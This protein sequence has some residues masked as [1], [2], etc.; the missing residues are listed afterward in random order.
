[1]KRIAAIQMTSSNSINENLEKIA[2]LVKKSV[3]QGAQ[4]VV[5]PENAVFIGQEETDKIQISEQVGKGP[6]QAFMSKIAK[7]YYIWLIGGTIPIKTKS[8]QHVFASCFVWD[9][10]GNAIARYDK[11][12]LFDVTVNST[13][14]YFESKTISPGHTV[15]SVNSPF[16]KIGLTICYDL[17]FPELYRALL[18][19]KVE[20]VVVASAFTDTTGK[21]HWESLLRARAIE[22]FCYIIAPNQTG[23]HANKKVTYGH[24]MIID[25]WG[26]VLA[27]LGKEE[28]VL[29]TDIDLSYLKT[30]RNTFPTLQHIKLLNNC[31]LNRI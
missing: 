6:I 12:H 1:M 23:I 16:G 26:K 19:Q 17:R 20:L 7:Q 18:Q 30:V 29:I 22:N 5:L 11:I 31:D 28:G 8:N 13:E 27:C 21:A 25:P 24:S 14:C 15:V 3:Q 4:L 10:R 9:N 2:E